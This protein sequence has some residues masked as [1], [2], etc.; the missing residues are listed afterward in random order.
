MENGMLLIIHRF[1]LAL[2]LFTSPLCFSEPPN[3][4]LL[5]K[6]IVVYHDS[7]LYEK[8][9]ARVIDQAQHFIQEQVY[10]NQ[11]RTNPKKLAI[12]LDI[13]ET[14]LSNYNHMVARHFDANM[15]Q[16]KKDILA[17][18]APAI[19]PTLALFTA[20]KKQGIDVFFVTGRSVDLLEATKANLLKAGFNHWAGLYFRP[21][22]YHRSSIIPF[23][24]QIRQN[25]TQQGY[26]IIASIGDQLS[27]IEG[28]YTQKGFK[29]PNPYYYLP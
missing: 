5:K 4:S 20:A 6:E 8:E 9:L 19:S 24:A 21:N 2:S 7:G 1:F 25:I 17:A 27:D 10:L 26:T 3:L 28:G 29:L 12:V 23:K 13:D 22:D 18:D 14:S 16:I 11:K 15:A